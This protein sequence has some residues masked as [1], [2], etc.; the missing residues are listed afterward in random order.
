MSPAQQAMSAPGRVCARCARIVSAMCA[1]H[2]VPLRRS[3]WASLCLRR[4]YGD[5][6]HRGPVVDVYRARRG[7]FPTRGGV[8]R[9]EIV[10][11]NADLDRGPRKKKC[12][13]NRPR[14][15]DCRRLNLPCQWSN[16]SISE[17]TDT[18][19]SSSPDSHATASPPQDPITISDGD[20]LAVS[21]LSSITPEDDEEF[22]ATL[23][24]HPLPKQNAVILPLERSPISTNPYL[25]GEEDRSLFNHY[26]HVVARA[27][28]RSHDPDRNPF[29][30]TLLPLAAASDAVTSVILSLSGC[31]WRRVYPS[32]WGC[33]LKR[34]GQELFD[35]TS[36]VWKWHL[37]AAS[38]I[39]KSPA[40]QNLASTDEWTFC[41]SLFHY[42][43]AMSTIS[44][45]KAPL[46]HNSDSMAE[47]TTSLRRNSVPQ[48]ERSQSTDA[49]YGISPALFDFLG[50]VN[51][52]ANHRSKRV[53]ELS[54]IGFRTAASHLENRIDEW[55]RDHDQITELEPETERATTAFEWAIRLRLHQVVEGYDP[56]HPFVERSITIILDS[57]QQIPYA[58]RVEGCLLFPL[59]IAGSSS[60][61]ME[62]RMMVKERL[63]VMENTLGFG[64]IQYARQLLETVWNGASCATDLNWAAVRYSKFPGVVF[65]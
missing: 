53:D 14:C 62:R 50:M 5:L 37:K 7:K 48:L 51:L 10:S 15:S 35:G 42:L 39:L 21:S 57:V 25:R 34:Q 19:S 32:I 11:A 58:S 18:P 55:R 46:L 17:T 33:A 56:L 22:I 28:S 59:V 13:E 40:F 4:P 52:L 61:S 65:V 26:I 9:F 29:L 64:H 54:E 30:V 38:A 47:L 12:D 8:A 20:P 45:C 27:L 31:H 3:R 24:P 6:G 1:S 60:I 49:I 43:D 2:G 23:F 63:M 16:A 41:I 44:R 36:K